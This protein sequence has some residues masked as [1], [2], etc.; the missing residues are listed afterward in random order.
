[1]S[2]AF[3]TWTR[4]AV[5]NPQTFYTETAY[6][7]AQCTLCEHFIPG[8]GPRADHADTVGLRPSCRASDGRVSW[9]QHS[10]RAEPFRY[11]L[12]TIVIHTPTVPGSHRALLGEPLGRRESVPKVPTDPSSASRTAERYTDGT[13]GSTIHPKKIHTRVPPVLFCL[14]CVRFRCWS[15]FGVGLCWCVPGPLCSLKG[16]K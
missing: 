6:R 14:V 4:G 1:M 3:Q 9:P 13:Q 12:I 2:E 15:A 7:M 5:H 10:V 11:H 8:A 16:L